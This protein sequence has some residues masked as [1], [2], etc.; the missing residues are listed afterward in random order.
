ADIE[1]NEARDPMLAFVD[2]LL[3]TGALTRE[4][5][6]ALYRDTDE[7][8]RRAAAEAVRR[9]KL[10]TRAAVQAPLQLPD[11]AALSLRVADTARRLELFDG[12]LPEDDARPRHMAFRIPQALTDLLAAYPNALLF[13]E[14]VAQKGG[15][16]HVT[17]GL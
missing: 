9:P 7:R 6:L 11:P 3:R 8:L 5:M 14:D 2:L 16:Y 12:R 15:V 1:A 13:G 4:A 10:S 17:S